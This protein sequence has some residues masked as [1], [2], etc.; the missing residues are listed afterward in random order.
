[1]GHRFAGALHVGHH[2]S[3]VSFLALQSCLHLKYFKFSL[4]R[5]RYSYW[6]S[7]GVSGPRAIFPFGYTLDRARNDPFE[8]ETRWLAEHG[9]VYGVYR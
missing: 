4:I 8:L 1:M 9:K 7:R 2:S 6:S 5:K 3:T